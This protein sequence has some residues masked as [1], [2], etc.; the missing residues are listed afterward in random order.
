MLLLVSTWVNLTQSGMIGA[1]SRIVIRGNNSLTGN[2]QAL[3]VLMVFLLMQ[4]VLNGSVTTTTLLVVVFQTLTLMM[5]N[6]FL[7]LKVQTLRHF[8]DQEQV[9]VY[10]LQLKGFIRKRSWNYY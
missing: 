10:L 1:G 5:L 7:F 8:T 4:M 2:T 9:M 3:I 6:L